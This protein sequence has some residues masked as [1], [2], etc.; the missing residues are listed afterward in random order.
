MQGSL[1]D[2]EQLMRAVHLLYMMSSSN[3]GRSPRLPYTEFFNK[4]VSRRADLA[5]E[6]MI[7][8][9]TLVQTFSHSQCC[10]PVLHLRQPASKTLVQA[11]VFP[12]FAPDPSLQID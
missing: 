8:R 10:P 9:H 12:L 11:Q 5:Q 1:Q 3:E 6:Y 7:W 4:E 2:R